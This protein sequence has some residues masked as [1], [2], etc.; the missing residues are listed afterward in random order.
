M[1][2]VLHSN[3]LLISSLTKD[4]I[5]SRNNVHFIGIIVGVAITRSVLY[6]FT[7]FQ[8]ACGDGASQALNHFKVLMKNSLYASF[9]IEHFDMAHF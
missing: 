2:L 4:V 6:Q 7:W 8:D 5:F 1:Q 9:S 3:A